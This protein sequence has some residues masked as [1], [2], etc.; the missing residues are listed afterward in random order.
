MV[1]QIDCSNCDAA[2]IGETGRNL[3]TRLS[4]HV[5][6]I[7]KRQTTSK[8]YQ[9]VNETQH[10][11]DFASVKILDKEERP[12]VRKNL[13]SIHS[14]KH[15]HPVNRYKEIPTLYHPFIYNRN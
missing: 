14:M 5:K 7:E 9:H 8:I 1:Y 10:S 4:E 15:P 3:E 2:Y 6:A 11:F 13:E 12:Y